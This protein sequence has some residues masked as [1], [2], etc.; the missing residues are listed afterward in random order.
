MAFGLLNATVP[1]PLT[2]DQV[3][4]KVP[5]VGRPSSLTAPLSVALFGKVRVKSGPAFTTGGWLAAFTTIVT[6]AALLSCPS[7]AVNRRTYVPACEK[8]AV[9]ALALELAKV[10]VPG[11]FSLLHCTVRV[12]DGKPSSLAAPLSV[13]ASGRVIV[14]LGPAVTTGG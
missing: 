5:P 11:P 1:G 12:P 6:S 3:M 7:L 4:V 14:W 2:F 10:T 9:V 13:A 8:F